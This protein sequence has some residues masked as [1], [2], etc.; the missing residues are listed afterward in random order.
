MVIRCEKIG[1]DWR[2][3]MIMYVC[4]KMYTFSKNLR[5]NGVGYFVMGA[6]KKN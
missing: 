5:I 4:N 1:P 2:V 6:E 3:V